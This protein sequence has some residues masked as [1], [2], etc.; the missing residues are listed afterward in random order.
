[1]CI[2]F[3]ASGYCM[4]YRVEQFCEKISRILP[5][6]AKFIVESIV[7]FF[8]RIY[9]KYFR[10][11]YSESDDCSS[12]SVYS[13]NISRLFQKLLLVYF[14]SNIIKKYS[15]YFEYFFAMLRL[16]EEYFLNIQRYFSGLF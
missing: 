11:V 10:N 9:Y 16:F 13:K 3:F 5:K 6:Y 4:Q 15:L 14:F 1:M 12:S 2:I 8:F 7:F